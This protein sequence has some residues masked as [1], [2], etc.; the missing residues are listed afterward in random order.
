MAKKPRIFSSSC[1]FPVSFL[2]VIPAYNE[3]RRLPAFLPEMAARI[4][5]QGIAA[6]I[7]VVDDGSAREESD[8]MKKTCAQAH[9]DFLRLDIN[10]GKGGAIYAAWQTASP[11]E[12]LLAFADADGSVSPAEVIRVL[13]FAEEAPNKAHFASRIKMRGRKVERLRRRHF[14][15]RIFAT[16]VGIFIDPE[17]YDSQCGMKIV[18]AAAYRRLMPYLQESG[19]AFDVEML[20]A[21]NHIGCPV[22][23]H[24]VDWREIP[25]SHVSV[26]SESIKMAKAVLSINHRRKHWPKAA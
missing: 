18:P 10:Q 11:E 15:G 17:I 24:P 9:V 4:A 3:A 2:L 6:R 26:I 7:C 22:V 25:G 21:L 8:A 1:N 5:E 19:F 16:L 12:T 23:E 20:A 13:Q 14:T